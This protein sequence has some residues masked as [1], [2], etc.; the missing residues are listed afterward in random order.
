MNHST[1][2]HP[3]ADG[4]SQS[5]EQLPRM[6]VVLATDTYETIRG[7]V[8]RFRRQTLAREIELV[9]VAPDAA[10]VDAVLAYGEEFAAV[11]IVEAPFTSV[12][13]CRAQGIR[14]ATA[15]VLFIAETHSYPHPDMAEVLS[16]AMNSWAAVTP[17]IGNANPKGAISWA[18]FLSDY[19][20][21]A[22]GLPA[23]EIPAP[24]PHNAA[25]RRSVLLELGDRLEPA[26]GL[27][28]EL[29]RWMRAHGH[30]TYF[31]PAARIDHVNVTRLMDSVRE[32]FVAGWVVASHR[33]QR[34]SLARRLV[35]VGGSIF[36]PAVLLWRVLPGVWQT[37]RH[38]HL[39]AATIPAMVTAAILKSIG[40]L[41]GYVGGEANYA[42]HYMQEYEVHKLAYLAHGKA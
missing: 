19:G 16:N 37:V 5:P 26:L 24:P 42:E 21:W 18:G 40:E 10:A 31:E 22:E 41:C 2:E 25:Y 30:R 15:P 6:S 20:L 4:L 32:R 36:I 7:V 39:P 11:K 35:Y 12:A 8:E 1:Q 13:F 9:L 29:P 28:D 38:R 14:A 34:W 23:G 17:A 3:I 27:G 33:A